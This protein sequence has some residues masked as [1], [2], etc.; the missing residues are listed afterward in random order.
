MAEAVAPGW[1][2]SDERK[3]RVEGMDLF[4]AES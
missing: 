1:W 2:V 3:V 4:L